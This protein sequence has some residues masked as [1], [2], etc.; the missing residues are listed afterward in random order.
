MNYSQHDQYYSPS[1]SSSLQERRKICI[2]IVHVAAYIRSPW[3]QLKL[4]VSAYLAF[5]EIDRFEVLTTSKKSLE[6]D[7]LF[8]GVGTT[9]LQ[10]LAPPLSF[11]LEG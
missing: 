11:L 9:G 4:L 8:S 5:G 2:T 6:Q 7:K 10:G 1:P 3:K